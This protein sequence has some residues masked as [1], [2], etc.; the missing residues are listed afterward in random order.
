MDSLLS[1]RGV[2]KYYDG[3]RALKDISIDL[4]AGKVR[5]LVGE[6]GAGKST[7]IK[8]IC[9]IIGHDGGTISIDGKQ[10]ELSNPLIAQKLGIRAVQQHFSLDE[11]KT[12]A[13][14]LFMNHYPRTKMGTIDWK[15][16]SADARKL[17]EEVGFPEVDPDALVSRISVEIG[18]AHV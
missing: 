8:I 16:M 12:V 17:L 4:E 14:N 15:R 2:S 18:R 13:E 11:S 1:I 9:G 5:A 6:N 10:V 3:V 7:L